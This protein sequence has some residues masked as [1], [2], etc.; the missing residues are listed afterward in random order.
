MPAGTPVVAARDGIVIEAEFANRAGGRDRRLLAR[1][2]VVRILH[3]DGSI[4]SYAHLAHSARAPVAVGEKLQ[5]GTV[6]G[7]VGATGYSAGPHLHFAVQKVVGNGSGFATV[8]LPVR[9]LLGNPPR[10]ASVAYRQQ[11]RAGELSTST[12]ARAAEPDR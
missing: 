3:A 2:N 8:S 7:A 5:A 6:I 11:L 4:A 1:A 12:A 9:F 10:A